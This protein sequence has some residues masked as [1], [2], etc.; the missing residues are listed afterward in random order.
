LF[1]GFGLRAAGTRLLHPLGY[2]VARRSEI[3]AVTREE[4]DRALGIIR[5]VIQNTRED[6]VAH[7]WGLIWMFHA[8]INL[9][10]CLV[11]WY[12]E[13]RNLSVAWYLVPLAVAGALNLVVVLLLVKRDQG[14]RSY[15]EWQIHGIWVTFIVFTA[16]MA[17]VIE[18]TAAPPRLFGS[19]FAMTSGIGFAMM[20]VVFQRQ[21]PYAVALLAVML[22]GPF[23]PGLQWLLIGIVWWCSLILTGLSMHREFRRRQQD[24]A[25]AKLL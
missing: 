11:G 22:V 17:V 23:V 14:I 13:N 25:H 4:A 24:A 16:A 18:L 1:R 19:V 7:N 6:L 21:L 15:V 5:Q 12:V 20:S 10:A 8:F 2:L 9:A 3:V